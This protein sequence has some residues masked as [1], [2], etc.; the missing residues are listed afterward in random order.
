MGRLYL[1]DLKL[2][3]TDERTERQ[4]NCSIPYTFD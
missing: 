3:Y 1:K 2:A 4:H